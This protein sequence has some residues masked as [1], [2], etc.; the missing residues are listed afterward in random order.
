MDMDWAILGCGY[1]GTRLADALLA[2]GERVRVCARRVDRLAALQVVGAELHS[3][4]A[5]KSRAFGPALHGLRSPVVVYS[6]PPLGNVPAGE[7]IRR[8]GDAAMTVG[9]SRFVYLSSTAVYGPNSDDAPVDEESSIM[10]T[11]PDAAARISEESAVETARLSGLQTV[12]L[13]LAAIYGPGRGVRER[14]RAGKYHLVDEGAHFFSR[15]HVDDIVAVVRAAVKRAPQGALY[16]VAD[17]RPTTQREYAEWLC[18]RLQLPL[19][20]SVASLAPGV[21]AR[22]VRNRRVS[23]AKLKREL[24]YSLIYPS[25]VEGE[26]AIEAETADRAPKSATAPVTVAA[27]PTPTPTPTSVSDYS[28]ASSEYAR[29]L[30][31]PELLGLQKDPGR[32]SH[33]DELLFQIIHQV[34]ELWMK[35]MAHEAG[36]AQNALERDQWVDATRSLA[37][38][39]VTGRLLSE[40]LLLFDTM[41]PAAYL[42]IRGGLGHASGLDSPGFIRLNQIAPELWQSFTRALERH[43]SDL[44]KLYA[45]AL[46]PGLAPILEVAEGLLSFDAAMQRFKREHLHVVRRII[47]MGTSSLRGN[48]SELLEKSAQ[49]TYFPLLWAAR[50]GLFADFK[51]GKLET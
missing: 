34:E 41:L 8:A 50:E 37:R 3:F 7:A 32:R 51:I 36:Q 6:I 35:A 30:R 49:K 44:I 24:C 11:D 33:P 10:L 27:T 42:S 40:Q 23:N 45:P 5:T 12:V 16:C 15:V 21:R 28:V 18:A 43:R 2:D 31:L 19:P 26:I 39:V 1:V 9:A 29:Y 20:P 22:R 17:D 47:G 14:L 25:Y 48:P 4:D 13:R 46:E 38:V